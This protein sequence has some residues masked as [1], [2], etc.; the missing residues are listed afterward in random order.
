[1]PYLPHTDKPCVEC[2]AFK[3][4]EDFA[5]NGT[6]IAVGVGHCQHDPSWR[7]KTPLST[8]DEGRNRFKRRG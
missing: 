4:R 2:E 7:F 3:S 8:C 1:M 6:I 5:K